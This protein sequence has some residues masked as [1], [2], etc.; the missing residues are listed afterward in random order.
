M[1]INAVLF[2]KSSHTICSFWP[3][4]IL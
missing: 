1:Y 3:V 4:V 2:L